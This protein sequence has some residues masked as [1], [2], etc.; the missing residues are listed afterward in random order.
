MT[1]SAL[2][3]ATLPG[4]GQWHQ[5]VSR[6]LA[7][8][9]EWNPRTDIYETEQGLNLQFDLP[10]VSKD[11]ID[12]RVEKGNLIVR[13]ERKLAASADSYH[14]IERPYGTFTRVFALPDHVDFDAV[15]AKLSDGVLSLY[16]PRREEAKPR[17]IQVKVAA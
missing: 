7:E 12:V 3:N 15:E 2:V 13:G 5:Q 14:R 1:A 10:G 17:Q 8:G 9:G 16:L 6:I 4:L 11:A